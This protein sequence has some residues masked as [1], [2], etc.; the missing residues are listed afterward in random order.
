MFIIFWVIWIIFNSNLTW[1]IAIIGA[2]VS[3]LMDLFL[4]KFLNY[5]PQTKALGL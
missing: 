2:A 3:L 4:R 5:H 1:Q